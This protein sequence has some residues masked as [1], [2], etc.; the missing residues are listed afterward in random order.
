MTFKERIFQAIIFESGAVALSWLLV[1]FVNYQPESQNNTPVVIAMLI[2]ISLIAMLWTF[3]YNLIFDRFFT[4]EKLARPVWLRGLHIVGFE[5]GLLCFTL[6]LV[7]WVMQIELWQ[8]F[9]L[10]ISLTLMILVYGFVF[11]WMY[12]WI[13]SKVVKKA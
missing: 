7:M 10:D 1:K 3:I 5:G 2:G 13:R 8:A 11:Y 9:L 6:P 4:E 12:D